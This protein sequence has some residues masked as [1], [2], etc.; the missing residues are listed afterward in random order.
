MAEEIKGL[1]EK[2]NQEGIRAG[3]EKARE[4]AALA[5]QK[6]EALIAQA[7]TKA[8]RLIAEAK[9]KLSR[10][11]EKTKTLLAQAA[12]DLLLALRKEINALLERIALA[13]IRQAL[14]PEV[15]FKLL[16][17]LIK[18]YGSKHSGDITVLLKKEDLEALEKGLLSK[19]KEEIKKGVVLK[20]TEDI[21]GGFTISFDRGKSCFD[22]T[23]KAMAEY[24]GAYLKP[25]LNQILQ[26]AIKT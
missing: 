14:T 18:G 24:I 6:A 5:E 1:I 2:I 20:P 16:S 17:E 9:E 23:D 19:L 7:K 10:E 25:K 15:I 22:F 4:I 11:E 8:E 21:S 26:E 3:E 12:R 13:E